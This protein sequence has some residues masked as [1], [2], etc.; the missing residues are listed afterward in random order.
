MSQH[1]IA[2]VHQD[3][4]K[5]TYWGN[6]VGGNTAAYKEAKIDELLRAHGPKNVRAMIDIG[7]GTCELL[8]RYQ[9]EYR[10]PELVCMDYDAKVVE[11][12]R[13]KYANANAEWVVEDIFALGKWTR[14]FDLIFLLDMVHEVYSFYGR[15]GRDIK[16]PVDHALGRKAVS[17]VLDNVAAIAAP[18]AGVVISDNVLCEVDGPVRLRARTAEALESVRY[19]VEHYTTRKFTS[20]SAAISLRSTAATS[21]SC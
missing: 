7:C 11:K 10:A 6:L 18:G 12:L 8:F 9:Q 3:A 14:K 21:A 17:D 19:F 13:Q 20:R 15:P 1:D 2:S 4:K 16:L 5:E